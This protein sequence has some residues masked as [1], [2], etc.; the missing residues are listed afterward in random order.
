MSESSSQAGGVPQ[1]VMG[2]G[3]S[4]LPDGSYYAKLAGISPVPEKTVNG[5]VWKPGYEFV[6][7][8][9]AGP[10]KGVRKP[11]I[12]RNPVP[13]DKNGL[14]RTIAGL[15][16]KMPKPGEPVNLRPCVGKTYMIVVQGGKVTGIS[17]PPQQ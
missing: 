6:F 4:A 7:E 14:G 17:E 13:T 16:G 10:H 3:G 8:V 9:Q 5:E 15:I 12:N 11:V 1:F 2:T